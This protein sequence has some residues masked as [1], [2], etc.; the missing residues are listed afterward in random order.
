MDRRREDDSGWEATG[1]RASVRS[2]CRWVVTG[3][4]TKD[5]GWSREQ[6]ARDATLC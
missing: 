5:Q 2:R 1:L 3:E 6:A 4:G